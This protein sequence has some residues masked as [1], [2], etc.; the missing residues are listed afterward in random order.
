MS[1]PGKALALIRT[2]SGL[3]IQN[4]PD[5]LHWLDRSLRFA[6]DVHEFAKQIGA[7]T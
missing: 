7:R 5:T 1:S 4:G 2:Y 3:S 6:F